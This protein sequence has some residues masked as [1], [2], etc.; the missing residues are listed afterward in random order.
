M[1]DFEN[2]Q[3]AR[4]SDPLAK[5][6]AIALFLIAG[7]LIITS[8]SMKSY[9]IILQAGALLLLTAAVFIAVKYVLRT[10]VYRTEKRESGDYDFVIVDVRGERRV[11][12]VRLS[13]A[14]QI[15]GYTDDIDEIAR[16]RKKREIRCYLYCTD[17]KPKEASLLFA[18]D[19]DEKIAVIF[20]PSPAMRDTVRNLVVGMHLEE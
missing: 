1:E 20:Q 15:T 5:W 19:G 2:E 3:I 12:S 10:F 8:L 9:R 13:F 11:V 6:L 14:N 18:H 4:S 16:I 17:M 7:G